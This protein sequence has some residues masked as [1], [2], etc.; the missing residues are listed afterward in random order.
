MTTTPRTGPVEP[1]PR[2]HPGR[3]AVMVVAL[4]VGL[5]GISCASDERESVDAQSLNGEW[6]EVEGTAVGA[7]SGTPVGSD[8]TDQSGNF[9]LPDAPV[10]QFTLRVNESGVGGFLGE[11]CSPKLCDSFAGAVSK[12]GT[13]IMAKGDATMT[14]TQYG[15]EIEV[16]VASPGSDFQVAACRMMRRA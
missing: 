9:I 3:L 7:L 11:W 2:F 13:A 8:H 6:V 12:D 16:C 14:L 10:P 15:D 5:L 1:Q 4:A